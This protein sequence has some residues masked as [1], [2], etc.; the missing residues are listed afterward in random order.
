MMAVEKLRP[1]RVTDELLLFIDDLGAV[2][3][4]VDAGL[5]VRPGADPLPAGIVEVDSVLETG[6]DDEGTVG[7]E[8][9]GADRMGTAVVVVGSPG[10]PG[11]VEDRLE[12]LQLGGECAEPCDFSIGGD[13][14]L[15]S[16]M[17]GQ[18]QQQNPLAGEVKILRDGDFLPL[19]QDFSAGSRLQG[20]PGKR[21]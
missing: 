3:V 14:L 18:A 5:F 20:T 8:T 10:S 11:V 13:S 16:L 21:M 9:D 19:E 2:R 15:A 6:S 1:A 17:L 7:E 12:V 4:G